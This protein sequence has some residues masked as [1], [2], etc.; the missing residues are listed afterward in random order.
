MSRP[1]PGD[2][3]DRALLSRIAQGDEA[4][5]RALYDRHE[6]RIH[7]F[8]RARLNDPVEAADIFND[9]MLEIWRQAR[10]YE[11]RAAVTTW[12]LGIAHF[13]VL[14]RHRARGR[15]PTEELAD[16]LPDTGAD[17][18]SLLAAAGDAGELRR[19]LSRLSQAH[20]AVVHLAFYEDMPFAE[21]ARILDCPETTVRTRMFYARK[22]LLRCLQAAGVGPR[23][24]EEGP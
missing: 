9:V 23:G 11:G 8:I 6:L 22:A 17:A 24:R 1:V 10:R 15:R 5:F 12:M 20:R 21:I 18:E 19:C 16:D 14:D 7:R 4:A 3:E 2:A 13:K